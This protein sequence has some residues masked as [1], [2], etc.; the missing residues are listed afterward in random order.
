MKAPRRIHVHKI[1]SLEDY[2]RSQNYFKPFFKH[3]SNDLIIMYLVNCNKIIY[4]LVYI[5]HQISLTEVRIGHHYQ[6]GQYGEN[7]TTATVIKTFQ[8]VLK[9]PIRDK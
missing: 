2:I 7:C 5:L 9:C 4:F 3:F 8:L 6:Y 1:Q